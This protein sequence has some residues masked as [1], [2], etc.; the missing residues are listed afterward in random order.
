M[1][2]YLFLVTPVVFLILC[3]MSQLQIFQGFLD[4]PIMIILGTILLSVVIA[5]IERNAKHSAEEKHVYY[6]NLDIIRFLFAIIVLIAHMRPFLGYN[7]HLD[8]AFNNIISRICVPIYFITTGYFC[9]KK[10]RNNP[11]YIKQYI[12]AMLPV[13]IVWSILYIPFG[14]EAIS[15]MGIPKV[16]FPVA[17][18][19]AFFYIG[20]Y[21]HLWYFPALFLAL[22]VLDRWR[23]HF[24][25]RS[26][27]VIGLL[28]LCF[29]AT[30]T[31][32]GMLPDGL[33]YF[34]STFY[35]KIFYTTRNF[36]FFG[37]FYVTL[38]YVIGSKSV[39][40]V[41]YCYLKLLFSC[42]LLVMEA[43]ILQ[44]FDRLDS[45]I[46]LACVP[47]TYYLFLILIH[48]KPMIS[49]KP[50]IPYRDLYKYYYF[51]HPAVIYL[52]ALMFHS[53]TNVFNGHYWVQLLIVILLVHG[54]TVFIIYMKKK[55]PHRFRHL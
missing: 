33:Q 38:G 23:K 53:Y 26:L 54:L 4:Q 14:I 50:K 44:S 52:T 30:E 31:Y 20:T 24:S 34:L 25:L 41:S 18:L 47:L 39:S 42:M 32:F 6:E 15:M 17:L 21:Y 43:L 10:Q 45:N 29:G 22:L 16:A 48:S 46:M 8:I 7:Y 12:K 37:L 55:F 5:Y 35:F 3:L 1:K 28:L 11:D 13:Y 9:A 51:L 27:L 2:K 40:Y 36:L 49:Y 19:V